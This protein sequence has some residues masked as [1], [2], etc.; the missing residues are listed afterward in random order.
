MSEG[1][2]AHTM[3]SKQEDDKWTSPISD[4]CSEIIYQVVL[5]WS[6]GTMASSLCVPS[7]GWV[8]TALLGTIKTLCLLGY[9]IIKSRRVEWQTSRGL[10]PSHS[11]TIHHAQAVQA[12]MLQVA[13]INYGQTFE[14]DSICSRLS[15]I[16]LAW[17]H[18]PQMHSAVIW[19]VIRWETELMRTCNGRRHTQLIDSF[20][21]RT[22]VLIPRDSCVG[23]HPERVKQRAWNQNQVSKPFSKQAMF[24][25]V[26]NSQKTMNHW[27]VRTG[28][29]VT[30]PSAS[31]LYTCL[32][33]TKGIVWN[34]VESSVC[35]WVEWH[36]QNQLPAPSRWSRW[37]GLRGMPPTC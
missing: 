2:H 27:V 16:P 14:C 23:H 25:L 32:G 30:Y 21:K 15:L 9:K 1:T 29:K 33:R 7:V 24:V 35:E 22:F 28:N 17:Q 11:P 31:P 20:A 34:G 3:A 10:N 19:C 36:A 18:S 26:L 5:G 6:S 8:Y 13:V 12:R 4:N 37:N